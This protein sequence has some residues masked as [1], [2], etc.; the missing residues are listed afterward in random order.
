MDDN[1][2]DS[3][4]SGGGDN[5]VSPPPAPPMPPNPPLTD[6]Q[7]PPAAPP[8]PPSVVPQI[9]EKKEESLPPP[10]LPKDELP[11]PNIAK[12][13][14]LAA[15]FLL[16][17][18]SSVA[19]YFLVRK[20]GLGLQKKATG[21]TPPAGKTGNDGDGGCCGDFTSVEG[22]TCSS[23]DC[24]SWETCTINN[25]AC[26]SG[27][28]CYDTTGG[29]TT[30]APG[31]IS[32]TADGQS[33]HI[34]NNTSERKSVRC[35]VCKGC[36]GGNLQGCSLECRTD[37][38]VLDPGETKLC[39]SDTPRPCE[40]IQTDVPECQSG[41]NVVIWGG[42]KCCN[43]ESCVYDGP[44]GN[45]ACQQNSDCLGPTPTATPTVTLTPTQTPTLTP[46]PTVTPT[47]TGTRIPTQ[48]PTS[49]L[50]LTPVPTNT[51]RP[52]ATPTPTLLPGVPTPTPQPTVAPACNFV[53]VYKVNSDGTKTQIN[54]GAFLMAGDRLYLEASFKLNTA[55]QKAVVAIRRNGVVV[56]EKFAQFI[57]DPPTDY[58]T[59]YRITFYYDITA[60]GNYEVGAFYYY[61][62]SWH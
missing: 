1:S 41:R 48:T 56:R 59:D 29:G 57:S 61:G 58:D 49:T 46:R 52:T 37:N 28:S 7:V 15:V 19:G 45:P 62:G 32:C 42:G 53:K 39:T 16:I 43:N 26:A 24:R 6:A 17:A 27:T 4:S 11:K 8:S 50:T 35:I 21:C 5:F 40:T 30:P 34:T 47:P 13:A 10:E 31:Q 3:V 38:M 14:V 23:G 55:V 2:S 60:T 51:P 20:G 33:V 9:E 18:V 25:G 54:S 44:I 22:N 12:S 36:R